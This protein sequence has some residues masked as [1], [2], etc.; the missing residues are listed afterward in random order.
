MALRVHFHL[1]LTFTS[2]LYA[3][4]IHYSALV[5]SEA[6]AV[7]HFLL[8]EVLGFNHV[9]YKIEK[10]FYVTHGHTLADS[11]PSG[12]VFCDLESC[13][14][15]PAGPFFNFKRCFVGSRGGVT[16]SAFLKFRGCSVYGATLF[17]SFQQASTVRLLATC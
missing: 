1:I 6:D 7:I 2:P 14:I 13:W 12:S 15:D 16:V 17:F 8:Y 4:Y 11:S 10:K 9:K 3:L 5:Q